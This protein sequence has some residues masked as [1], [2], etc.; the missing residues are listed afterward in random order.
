MF[1]QLKYTQ[2]T[3]RGILS[4]YR[5]FS[6]FYKEGIHQNQLHPRAKPQFKKRR[7]NRIYADI[8]ESKQSIIHQIILRRCNRVPVPVQEYVFTDIGL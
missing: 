3:L 8:S 4:T 7:G 5:G 2:S 6:L 1:Y